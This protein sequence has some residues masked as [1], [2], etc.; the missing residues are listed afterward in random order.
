[1]NRQRGFGV[2]AAIVILVI[3]AVLAAAIVSISNTQQITSAQD[4]L[5]ARAWQAAR[6]G[7]EW[8]LYKALRGEAWTATAGDTCSTAAR[9]AT[10]DLAADTGFHV[11]VSCDSSRYGEGEEIVAGALQARQVRVYRITAIAC[12]ANACPAAGGAAVA[13]PGYVERRRVVLAT[14]R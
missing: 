4:V 6:A 8:G 2:I 1:M 10:L 3:L 12:P 11:T 14:D 5:S 13:A 7:S 9:G